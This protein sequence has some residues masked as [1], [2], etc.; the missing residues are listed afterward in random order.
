MEGK[1]DISIRQEGRQRSP[2][3][4]EGLKPPSFVETYTL[5]KGDHPFEPPMD[6]TSGNPMVATV[7]ERNLD[8]LSR[9]T[10]EPFHDYRDNMEQADS[11]I[12]QLLDLPPSAY[13]DFKDSSLDI[14]DYIVKRQLQNSGST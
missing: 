14:I 6:L 7:I 12:R 1:A 13:V 3:Y 8:W 10:A 5:T 2:W 4:T 11:N 9:N